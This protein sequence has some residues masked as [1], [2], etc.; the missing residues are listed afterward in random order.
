MSYR[1]GVQ[2]APEPTAESA[3]PWKRRLVLSG[4]LLLAI[5][6]FF[7]YVR[8]PGD[9]I[10]YAVAG[11][12]VLAG[13]DIYND[14]PPDLNNWPPF[15][16]LLCVPLAL[17]DRVSPY[18][19][20]GFWIILNYGVLLLI[21]DMVSRLVYGRRLTLSGANA[22][23]SLAS[24]AILVPIMLTLPF[25]L[26][27]FMYQQVNLIIFALTLGGLMLQEKGRGFLGGL[28]LGLAA[29][30]KVMPVLFVPYLAYR[31]R[32]KPALYALAATVAFSV[33]PIVVFG[34]HRFLLDFKTWLTICRQNPW[35]TGSANQSIY[36]MWDR[37]LG[38][39]IVPFIS[40]GTFF[41]PMSSDPRVRIAWMLSIACTGVVV[42]LAFRGRP[43]LGSL[44]SRLEWSV[45]FLIS[46]IFG[47]VG[48]KHYLVVLILA[49]ALLYALYRSE[50][51]EAGT[52]RVLGAVLLI[53]FLLS[54]ATS[55]DV[56]GRSL[57]QR[58]ETGAI[59]T[60]AALILLAG[61]LWIRFQLPIREVP[62]A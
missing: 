50:E 52:R 45:V 39:G 60:Y 37:F 9:F 15:F 56:V 3:L 18:L 44:S 7:S 59:I 16:S 13:A 46:A 43:P 24:S 25:L 33:S 6:L 57:V 38:H 29:A 53:Y 8:R 62:V 34:P 31:G 1:S 54:L 20:R 22:T 23:V 42:L 58:F 17:M 19:A 5:V 32:W 55:H 2:L 36:A 49:N 14:T 28:G 12:A 26:Y 21:L 47:P 41:L 11:N 35:G 51:L 40:P 30:M 61:L 4:M 10:G 27:H 48:W